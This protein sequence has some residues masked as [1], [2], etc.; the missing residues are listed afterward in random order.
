MIRGELN[1]EELVGKVG[2][3][4]LIA[5]EMSCCSD[6]LIRNHDLKIIKNKKR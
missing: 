6:D 1:W 5:M 4:S 2:G 3:V